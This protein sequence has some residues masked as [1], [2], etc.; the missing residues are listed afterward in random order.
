[1]LYYGG[2]SPPTIPPFAQT[3]VVPQQ[4]GGHPYDLDDD[5]PREVPVSARLVGSRVVAIGAAP[6]AP[7]TGKTEAV[8][9]AVSRGSS[10]ASW[11]VARSHSQQ[12]L[13]SR[14]S[15]RASASSSS[16]FPGSKNGGDPVDRIL[17]PTEVKEALLKSASARGSVMRSG[18]RRNFARPTISSANRSFSAKALLMKVDEKAKTD[19][20]RGEIAGLQGKIRELKE[21]RRRNRETIEVLTEVIK[22]LGRSRAF[23]DSLVRSQSMKGPFF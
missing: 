6:V 13:P 20:L 7:N 12:T 8:V 15:V 22:D 1:M 2:L 9:P 17:S 4:P 3:A 14:Q 16:F 21:A 11:G 5:S 18:P 23:A 10:F 19:A